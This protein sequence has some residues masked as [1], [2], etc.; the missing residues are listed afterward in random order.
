MQSVVMAMWPTHLY[1][2]CFSPRGGRE[3]GSRSSTARAD[4]TSRFDLRSDHRS[5]PKKKFQPAISARRERRSNR[6]ERGQS[7]PR[8]CR[9][10]T[11]A[12]GG[13]PGWTRLATGKRLR[14]NF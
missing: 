5:T 11:S 8:P 3:T 7:A 9:G 1:F 2:Q 10:A 12:A 6:L 4:R 14:H 13:G